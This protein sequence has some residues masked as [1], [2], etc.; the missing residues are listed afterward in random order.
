[1]RDESE[2]PGMEINEAALEGASGGAWSRWLGS[3]LTLCK[4]CFRRKDHICQHSAEEL[5][6]YMRKNAQGD[7]HITD[8]CPFMFM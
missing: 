3:A 7:K 6:E 5:A 2:N 1:M 8:R 4:D